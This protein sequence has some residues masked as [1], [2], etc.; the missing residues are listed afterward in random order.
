ML[1]KTLNDGSKVGFKG[2]NNQLMFI[3]K[4]SKFDSKNGMLVKTEEDDS[5]FGFKGKML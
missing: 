1:D 4:A 3:P 2:F 5:K